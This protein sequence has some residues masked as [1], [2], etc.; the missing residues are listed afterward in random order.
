MKS[1]E[2]RDRIL[3][4]KLT[5]RIV[6]M[7]S[8]MRAFTVFIT[9]VAYS[10]ERLAEIFTFSASSASEVRAEAISRSSSK[11]LASWPLVAKTS[12]IFIKPAQLIRYHATV[13]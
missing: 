7:A 10:T 5:L 1:L 2:R 9:G 8:W 6:F 3:S 4:T 11:V 12:P 13:A